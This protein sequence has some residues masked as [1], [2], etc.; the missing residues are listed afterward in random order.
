MGYTVLKLNDKTGKILYGTYY[1]EFFE[2]PVYVD[3]LD[4]DKKL[5][6]VVKLTISPNHIELPTDINLE[7]HRLVRNDDYKSFSVK[8]AMSIQYSLMIKKFFEHPEQFKIEVSPKIPDGSP[9]GMD[10]CNYNPN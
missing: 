2:G 3:E 10:I 5:N 4:P 9:I 1:L 8:D 7:D 6:W